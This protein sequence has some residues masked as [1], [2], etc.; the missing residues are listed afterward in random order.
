MLI[1]N[2]MTSFSWR[3]FHVIDASSWDQIGVIF[4]YVEFLPL[5]KYS[6]NDWRSCTVD[7][8]YYSENMAA[9]N[10]IFWW[11]LKTN[12]T[13]VV[14]FTHYLWLITCDSLFIIHES[15]VILLSYKHSTRHCSQVYFQGFSKSIDLIRHP[16]RMLNS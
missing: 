10:R 6:L 7:K 11:L 16:I 15:W 4:M 3:N 13:K 1:I 9:S 5:E 8:R 14:S 12:V 2:F